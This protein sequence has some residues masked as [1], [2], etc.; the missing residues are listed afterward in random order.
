MPT[1][2]LFVLALQLDGGAAACSRWL[3][4]ILSQLILSASPI[5]KAVMGLLLLFS[6]ISWGIIL[7]KWWTFRGHREADS[8][9]FLEVFRKS[10]KFSEVQAVCPSLGASPLVGMFQAGYA[11]LTAQLR[12]SPAA[13]A[14]PGAPCAASNLEEHHGGRPRAAARL[15]D[16]SEQAR[17]A[18]DVPG[19]D[20][21]HHAVHRAV[22]NGVGNHDGVHEHRR[23]GLDRSRRRRT[24]IAEAL[25]ATALGPVRGD[26]GRLLLQPLH[27][28]GEDLRVGDGRLR[29]R[30]PEHLGKELHLVPKV[31]AQPDANTGRR[32]GRRVTTS[33]SEINVI[34]LVDVML[35]LLII[36]MVAAPMMQKGVEVNLPVSRRADKMTE[37]RRSTSRCRRRIAKDRRVFIDDEAVPVDV[38]AERMRQAML[39][40]HRQGGVPARR[41]RRAAAGADGRVRPP[42]GRRRREG[43]HRRAG[44]AAQASSHGR[45]S[46]KSSSRGR[47]KADGLSSMVGASAM[48]HLVLVAAVVPS[49][50]PAGSARENEQPEV[51][52]ADQPRRPGRAARRRPGD[53]RRP[54]RFS[55]CAGRS[56]RRRSNRCVRRRRR[57]RR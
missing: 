15:V 38:L 46:P 8:S 21:E 35:V 43:R 42:E 55:R 30:V 9:T 40:A 4:E 47:R 31:M 44:A 50:R 32:R 48:A 25:I 23:A 7:Y 28:E 11:E 33:L 51:D 53:A 45:A 39:N 56:R 17:E 37:A 22:R 27:V 57:R 16:R 54:H 12:Q 2:G 20:R 49:C 18:R 3:P 13:P 26:S 6:V 5:V 52:H 19:D 14:S 1:P 10:A 29:A 24:P 36:F 34:P 41:R